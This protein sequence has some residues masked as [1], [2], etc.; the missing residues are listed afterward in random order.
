MPSRQGAG[1]TVRIV[2]FSTALGPMSVAA[3]ERGLVAASL[4]G[5][6]RDHVRRYVERRLPRAVV[7]EQQLAARGSA[8]NASEAAAATAAKAARA[9]QSFLAGKLRELDVPLDL[10]GTP[11]QL[12][13]WRELRRVPFGQTVSYGELARRAGHPRAVRACGSA[14]GAN[15]VPLFVPCHRTIAGDGSIGGYGGRLSLKRKLLALE[16]APHRR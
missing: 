8:T 6:A 7:V 1:E 13:V 14:H 9:A 11:F 5:S 12:Q 10:R 3:S 15:P 2:H 16:S 4:P